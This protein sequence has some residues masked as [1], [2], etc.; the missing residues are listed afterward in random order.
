MVEYVPFT[1]PTLSGFELEAFAKCLE[2]RSLAGGGNISAEAASQLQEICDVRFTRV[3]HSCTAALEAAVIALRIGPGDEVILPSYN[4]PSAANA[5]VLRGATPIFVDIKPGTM[6]ID[7]ELIEQAI[8]QNTKAII[9]V[10][11][12]GVAAEMDKICSIAQ[13]Y[14]LAIIEDAAQGFYSAYKGRHLGGIGTIGAIS[15]HA[16]KNINSGEGGALLLNDDNVC[17]SLDIIIEKGTNRKDFLNGQV[18]KYHWVDIGSSYVMS[19]ISAAMLTAQLSVAAQLTEERV[20]LWQYYH[21]QLSQLQTDRFRLP[22]IPSHCTH[23]GHLFYVHLEHAQ[24]RKNV[25]ASLAEHNIQATGHFEPLHLAPAGKKWGR[26][27]G[28]MRQTERL[29]PGLIRLPLWNGMTT[30]HQN[31]V[32]E[33]FARALKAN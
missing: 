5:I 12:A 15:F 27:S 31:R 9:P 20:S 33:C 25:I 28:T 4:F 17:S 32:I 8:T 6:N 11:Y 18:S 26:V 7:E 30:H 3:V 24:A 14:D 23:N 2:Q 21:N 1:K 19:D 13:K 16:T 29:A 22:V 10:H